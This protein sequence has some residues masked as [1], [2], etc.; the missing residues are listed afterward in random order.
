MT[1]IR[2]NEPNQRNSHIATGSSSIHVWQH[3]SVLKRDDAIRSQHTVRGVETLHNAILRSPG[4]SNGDP[5]AFVS[6]GAMVPG[7]AEL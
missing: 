3:N 5:N 2:M 6:E 1:S 4:R 7:E